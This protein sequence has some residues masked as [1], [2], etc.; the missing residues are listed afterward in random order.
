[1]ATENIEF[2][3]GE[4]AILEAL[5]AERPFNLL[6][7]RVKIPEGV[8]VTIEGKK[9]TVKGK[10]GTITKD[11]S[12]VK[13]VYIFKLDD[14]VVVAAKVTNRNEKKPVATVATKIF[15]M[16]DGV[17][18]EYIYKHKVVFS[19]FPIRVKIEGK[20]IIVENFIGR[21]DRIIIPIYGENTKVEVTYQPG[22]EIP[23]EIIIRGPDLEAVSQTSGAIHDKLKLRGKF[24]KDPRVFMDGIWRYEVTREEEV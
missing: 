15:K 8:E 20:K 12:H 10:K 6:V 5:K 23:D 1:M 9:V 24:R 16:I 7:K 14:E 2:L 19:H 13:N 4:K 3:V 11:F 21:K 22:S 18:R 17:Q